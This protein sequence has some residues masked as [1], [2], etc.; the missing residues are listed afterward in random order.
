MKA[1]LMC[2]CIG[3]LRPDMWRDMS[4]AASNQLFGVSST[5]WLSNA[6]G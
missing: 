4:P 5:C 2:K 1:V 3:I 6:N